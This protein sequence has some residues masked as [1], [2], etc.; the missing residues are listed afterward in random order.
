MEAGRKSVVPSTAPM[1]AVTIQYS[2][3]KKAGTEEKWNEALYARL[4]NYFF[5]ATGCTKNRHP[6][7]GI[8]PSLE[9]LAPGGR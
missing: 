5:A 8:F 1:E 2:A 4:R 7:Y 3:P 6:A 9:L